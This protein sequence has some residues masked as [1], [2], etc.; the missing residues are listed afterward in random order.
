[1]PPFAILPFVSTLAL[2]LPRNYV[3]AHFQVEKHAL[4]NTSSDPAGA[5]LPG[6][7]QCK[8]KSHQRVY[9]CACVCVHICE[10][11]CECER[12]CVFVCPEHMQ[13]CT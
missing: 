6:A 8:V 3:R 1:M 4:Q 9:V 10:C 13:A 5:P 12:V 11:E 2:H 7:T